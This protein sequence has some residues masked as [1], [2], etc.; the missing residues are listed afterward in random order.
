[1]ILIVSPNFMKYFVVGHASG[2]TLWPFVV[3]RDD[4]LLKNARLLNHEKIHLR[5]QVEMGLIFFY[6]WYVVEYFIRLA[7]HRKH[8]K[9]Y[10]MIS[11]EQEAF[12]NDRNLT[13]LED[14]KFWGF[15]KKKYF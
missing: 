1:M 13:Y 3:L 7:I 6:I 5:Q 4:T 2:I 12:E 9:A 8:Y 10:R 15:L 14:R 11:F